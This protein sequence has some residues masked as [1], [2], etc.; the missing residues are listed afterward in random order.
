MEQVMAT[1]RVE[2]AIT[3]TFTNYIQT[4]QTLDPHATIRY[5]HVPCMFISPQGLRV[6]AAPADVQALLAQVMEDLK[7][8]GYARSELL[9]L[10]V[11]QMSGNTALV[12]VSRARYATDGR[13]LERLGETYTLRRIES[14]WKIAVAMIHDPDVVLR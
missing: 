10:H 5:F 2:E 9:D 7:A 13:E 14:A 8:R 4:F 12:T 3:Q 6:L 1:A 11:N